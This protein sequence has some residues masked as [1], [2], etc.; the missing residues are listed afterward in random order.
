[1]IS[2]S[3]HKL[4]AYG[5][6]HKDRKRPL[7][8]FGYYFKINVKIFLILFKSGMNRINRK[9]SSQDSL[10]FAGISLTLL[11]ITT[12]NKDDFSSYFKHKHCS[13]SNK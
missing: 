9:L 7:V 2:F 5:L 3:V 6:V 4:S 10:A 1:M 12:R 13:L 8:N 11:I